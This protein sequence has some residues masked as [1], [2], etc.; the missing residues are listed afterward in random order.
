MSC[1]LWSGMVLQLSAQK[2]CGVI[3]CAA[4][5]VDLKKNSSPKDLSS[6]VRNYNLVVLPLKI[7]F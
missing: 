4:A 3:F 1:M 5:S 2:W 6:T 7:T